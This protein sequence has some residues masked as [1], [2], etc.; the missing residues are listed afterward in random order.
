MVD[1]VICINFEESKK[2][3]SI[4][5]ETFTGRI[6]NLKSKQYSG[7]LRKINING[8]EN[9]NNFSNIDLIEIRRILNNENNVQISKCQY[10]IS[11]LT[12]TKLRKYVQMGAVFYKDKNIPMYMIEKL[13][14]YE[15]IDNAFKL[16]DISYTYEKT[17]IQFSINKNSCNLKKK[18]IQPV[19]Y[20]NLSKKVF[21][22]KLVFEYDD[23]IIEY[24]K[25]NVVEDNI[26]R[27]FGFEQRTLDFI[28]NEGWRYC[29]EGYFKYCDKDFIRAIQRM[30]DY[31]IL[32]YS[33]ERKRIF[34]GSI[35]SANISYNIDWFEVK[36]KIL[37]DKEEHEIGELINLAK[38]N[39]KWIELNNQ[40]TLLPKM[41]LENREIFEVEGESVK[42]KKQYIGNLLEFADSIG[43]KEIKNI[44]KIKNYNEI[45]LEIDSNIKKILRNYQ[46]EGV[47]WLIYLFENGF[48]GCLADDM[49][50]GKTLQII[51]YLS[52]KRFEKS[53]LSLIVVPKTLLINWN[54]EFLKFAPEISIY[55]YHGANRAINRIN[56]NRIVITT[57]GTLINDFNKLK[58]FQYSNIIVDEAQN[59]KNS[60]SKS[61]RTINS[62]NSKTKIMM[63]GTPLENNLKEFFDLMRISNPS[64]FL[65]FNLLNGE[66]DEQIEKIKRISSPFVLRRMK[67]DVLKSLPEKIE[68]TIYC[69]L[70]EKQEELYLKLLSSIQFELKRK[71]ERYEIKSNAIALKGLLYL[72]EACCHPQLLPV[73]INSNNCKESTKIDVLFDMLHEL[74]ENKHKIVIFSRF[75]KMLHL[76][77]KRVIQEHMN[78][79][80][81]DGK[82]TNRMEV[83][84][85][86]ENSLKGIFLI[87]LKAGG[88]GLNLVSAD[89]A[90]IYD[91]WW[92]PAV[93]KQAEDRIYRIGQKRNVTIYRLIV[94]NTIEEKIEKLKGMKRKISSDILE[95]EEDIT[96]ISI[97]ML[98]NIINNEE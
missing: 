70:G 81:L 86:F 56:R 94:A 93:E 60:N 87:S 88:V 91:P 30:N 14:F 83:V 19:L 40:I 15:Y 1:L 85:E 48:G 53:D 76:I 7:A 35:T 37:V 89:T 63:T 55:I 43:V 74:Y 26:I 59:I 54:R 11:Q 13:D 62:L 39:K 65:N 24:T 57:Y 61:Y 18:N 80:Y 3:D 77:E 27:N 29:K 8:L 73:E 21:T 45:E 4:V 96:E 82:T 5:I 34:V 9:V 84:D 33:N 78:Y 41:L 6:L 90:I 47:K 67:Q 58:T 44:D 42:V 52:D 38:P 46:L 69:N 98:M 2:R 71:S 64:V 17:T 10:I 97:E 32:I 51:A 75:T 20:I 25:Y 28:K 79:F 22:A 36:G 68:Q 23:D 66:Q 12:L 72:Q 49:G 95:G 50:L 31:G 16:H 92:N